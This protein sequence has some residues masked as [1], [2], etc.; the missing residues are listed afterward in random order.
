MYSLE[1]RHKLCTVSDAVG[2]RAFNY[3]RRNRN[4]NYF[5]VLVFTKNRFRI[6][7]RTNNGM[8]TSKTIERLEI[9]HEARTRTACLI[10]NAIDCTRSSANRE[11]LKMA[12]KTKRSRTIYRAMSI[13]YIIRDWKWL[14]VCKYIYIYIYIRIYTLK[15]ILKKYCLL[16]NCS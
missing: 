2:A 16:E 1:C 4:V 8:D 10:G 5:I 12:R 13:S 11:S 3:R 14:I 9:G 6:P 15:N 7:R